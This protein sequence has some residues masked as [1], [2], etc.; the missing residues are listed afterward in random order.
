MSVCFLGVTLNQL[1]KLWFRVPR[2][3][4]IDPSFSIVEAARAAASGYS[5]PSGHTQNAFGIFGCVALKGA[6]GALPYPKT[7][8]G[9]AV[10]CAAFLGLALLVGL[11]RM[12]LGVHTIYDVS[13]AALLSAA[14]VFLF[15]PAF[16][17]ARKKDAAPL[18]IL[19]MTAAALLFLC[20]A[21][22]LCQTAGN[23]E[24]IRS[25]FTH[26]W[27]MAGGAAGVAAAYPIEKRFVAF[28]SAAPLK[29]QLFKIVPGF[30][31][32]LFLKSTL[33]EP[34]LLL[35]GGHEAAHALRYFILVVFAVAVWPMC[36]SRFS[37]GAKKPSRHDIAG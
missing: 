30:L 13:F 4:V 1:L 7:K 34:L 11:S 29:V 37:K 17:D 22:R 25:A 12:Y 15:Y 3:W 31:A 23:E 32:V 21:G 6:A 19:L 9:K 10:F 26:A 5:F 2:P 16:S 28:S 35:F 20:C 18:V 24:N 14:L 27:Y 8:R 36:F 33:K